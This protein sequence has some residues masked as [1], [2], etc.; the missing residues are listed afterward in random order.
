MLSTAEKQIGDRLVPLHNTPQ[1]P[2]DLITFKFE[3]ALDLVKNYDHS[4]FAAGCDLGRGL[5]HLLELGARRTRST[6]S[7]RD[8]R[9]PLLVEGDARCELPEEFLG[10]LEQLFRTATHRLGD[11]L[12]GYG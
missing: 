9:P 7:K 6:H 8:F 1:L 10:R 2:F 5:E 3:N 11:G 12:R 4:P